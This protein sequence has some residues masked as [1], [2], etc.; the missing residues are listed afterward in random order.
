MRRSLVALIPSAALFFTAA[1][2]L[3]CGTGAHGVHARLAA[4]CGCGSPADCTCKKGDCKCR[5]C[6][7]HQGRAVE[8]ETRLLD[9]LTG[10]PAQPDLPQ[11]ARLEASGGTMI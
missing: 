5:N 11:N 1:P 7:H 4:T 10:Q 8:K 6:K 9:P 2:A 3:A